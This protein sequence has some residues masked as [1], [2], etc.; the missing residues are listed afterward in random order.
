MIIAIV[1]YDENRCIAKDGKI[2]WHISEDMQH[3][4]DTT[5]TCPLIMGRKT[6]DSLPVKPLPKRTNIVVSRTKHEMLFYSPIE[7]FWVTSLDAALRLVMNTEP[8]SD[9]FIIG[10]GEIYKEALDKG[11]VHKVIASE[12][13]GSF[14]GDTCFPEL[15]GWKSEVKKEFEEFVVKEYTR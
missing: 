14:E 2:P 8:D 5:G 9:V 6:W 4:K 11:L 1:S 12:I 13:K 3:F 7:P 10:G 15:P